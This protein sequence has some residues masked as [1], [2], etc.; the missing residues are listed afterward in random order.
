[1][2]TR[3]ALIFLVATGCATAFKGKTTPVEVTSNTPGAAI[4]VDGKPAGVTPATV[5]VSNKADAV[6]TVQQNGHE[7]T[8]HVVSSASIGWVVAD[9]FL[10]SGLGL[11]VDW[12]THNWNNVTP[13]SCHV[14]V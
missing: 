14:D 2:N 3:T 5:E 8:C 12:A 13:S 9:V 1:M 6:I 4:A 10:T 11:I 7:Q